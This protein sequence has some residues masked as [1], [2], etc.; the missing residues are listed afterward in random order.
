VLIAPAKAALVFLV[1]GGG[2][3]IT[4]GVKGYLRVPFN[5]VIE[6]VTLA[7]D[8][9]GSIQVDIWKSTYAAFPPTDAGSITGGNESEITGSN[10]GEDTSL[11]DWATSLNE[12]DILAFNV[13]SA[14]ALPGDDKF[15]GEE[16]IECRATP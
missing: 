3:A 13:D 1:D 9:V 7:A 12:G 16:E 10:K 8:Q 15:A 11:T 14:T 2:E 6:R 4:A 5:C